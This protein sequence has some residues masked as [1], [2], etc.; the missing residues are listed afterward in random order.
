MRALITGGMGHVGGLLAAMLR[1]RGDTAVALDRAVPEGLGVSLDITDGPAINDLL[2]R[3]RFDAIFHLAG[4][5]AAAAPAEMKRVNIEG[6]RTVLEAARGIGARLLVMSS[7]AVYGACTDDPITENAALAPVM[8]YGVSKVVC[9]RLA[10]DAAQRDWVAIA[11]PFNIIGPGQRAAMLQTAVLSQLVAIERGEAE[12]VLK[13]GWLGNARDFVD[14]RDVAA[15]LIAIIEKGQSGQA[16]NLC[17]GEAT[18]ARALVEMLVQ[19]SNKDIIIQDV[20]EKPSSADVPYQRGSADKLRHAGGWALRLSL[21][22]SL[23]DSLEWQ[24][25]QR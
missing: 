10:G 20:K 18:K 22:Q 1:T 5:N 6:T 4:L 17:S 23:R 8:P 16:Y 15:G 19:I 14:A 11:R 12:P 13:L 25:Q 9:E 7:S 21:H 2:R 3:E 24:R